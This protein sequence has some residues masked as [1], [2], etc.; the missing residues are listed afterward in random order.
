M[1]LD[2][3]LVATTD[4]GQI[5]FITRVLAAAANPQARWTNYTVRPHVAVNGRL[6]DNKV[7][8]T[9]G[10]VLGVVPAATLAEVGDT[11]VT[12]FGLHGNSTPASNAFSYTLPTGFQVASDGSTTVTLYNDPV[13]RD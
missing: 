13:V 7:A 12:M 10:Q 1:L 3:P 11:T 4:T 5:R 8:R 9:D 6:L 2:H